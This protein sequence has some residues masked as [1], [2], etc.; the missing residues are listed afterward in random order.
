MAAKESQRRNDLKIFFNALAD[1]PL[2]PDDK[3]YLKDLHRDAAGGD[4]ID[5]LAAQ[6]L[7]TEG[8]GVYPFTGNRGTGKSTELR[9]LKKM[10]ED[11]GCVVFLADMQE[12]VNLTTAIEISDF[13]VAVMGALSE[14]VFERYNTNPGERNYWDRLQAFFK[15]EVKLEEIELGGEGVSFKLAMRDD[16]DFRRR[17]QE[18]TRGHVAKLVKDAHGFSSEVV[19]FVRGHEKDN[20]KK[21]VLIVDSVEQIRGV[22]EDA[23]AVYK[24]V[25]NL[26]SGHADK[27]HLP[28][29]HVVYTVPPY[30]TVL[31]AGIGAHLGGGAVCSIP[32]IHIFERKSRNPD[33]VGVQSMLDVV[34]KRYP[35]WRNVF[36]EAALA[37]LV[38]CSGGDLRDCFRLMRLCLTAAAA[39]EATLPISQGVLVSAKN[40]LRNDMLPIAEDDKRWLK[41]ITKTYG[42]CL[43]SQSQLP[44]LARFFDTKLVLNYLNGE[45]WYDI[46]PLIRTD[47]DDFDSDAARPGAG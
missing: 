46:H 17:I 9:R 35:G 33:K 24:S 36:D 32:S 40:R 10:L 13:I 15:S 31:A 44:T 21:I 38:L 25:E 34:T 7:F 18:R 20:S 28:A 43:G 8:E 2:E 5:T 30:L 1:R 27:L 19:R 47:I 3:A 23:E 6:I 16:P 12:Y 14:K 29:L 45:E 22:G 42:A 4:P 37:D 41:R 11:Q 26:F 39:H